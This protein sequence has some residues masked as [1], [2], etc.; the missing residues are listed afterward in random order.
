MEIAKEKYEIV[1]M[2][3]DTVVLNMMHMES[4]PIKFDIDIEET[5]PA[6][7][8]GDE[9]RIKQ[10]INNVLSNAFK[11][12][13]EGFVK[14]TVR[15][16]SKDSDMGLVDLIVIISDTGQGMTKDQIDKLFESYAR[17]NV[18]ANRFI[19]GSG[20]GMSI[21]KSIMDIMRGDII[22]E[23][24][25]DK[26]STFTIRIPQIKVGDQQ[27]GKGVVS[28]LNKFRYGRVH[29]KYARIAQEPMP[30]G[31]V[32][33]VDDVEMNIYVARGLLAPYALQIDAVDS[34]FAAI[35]RI[36]DGNEYDI[37]FMDHMMPQMDGIEA[38]KRIR[39]MGYSLPIVALTANA[40]AGQ[41][42]VFLKSGFDD[43]ISKPIDIRQLNSVLN[44]FIRDKRAHEVMDMDDANV[45]K[46]EAIGVENE[47]GNEFDEYMKSSGLYDLACRD[48]L[49]VQKDFVSELTLAI[50]GNDLKRAHFLAHTL[51][52]MAG[53]IG[54]NV[55]VKL[56]EE[57]ESYL[58][59]DILPTGL[60]ALFLE[61]E[62]V[63]FDIEER[64]PQRSDSQPDDRVLDKE[65]AK[66]VFDK[67]A[68]LLKISSFDALSLVDELSQIPKTNKLIEQIESIDF[69]IALNTLEE[70]RKTLE[71]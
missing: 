50:E 25:P 71:V 45:A 40:I 15:S 57:T 42:D 2:I 62:R 44:K 52:G 13:D 67:L 20:L 24:E 39:D 29:M 64:Y 14:M 27:V 33:I 17:F 23:S 48:F 31:Q 5:I 58:R 43:F 22:V 65:K 63:L 53:L 8:L 54:E 19:E 4:K 6:Y 68:P 26:G 60:D 3:H 37:I 9:L 32:L 18:K 56:S 55:L 61:V 69:D 46:S 1:S 21:T 10:V 7:M 51:K 35:Q 38:T 12:T 41:L 36:K 11:Y 59:K 28:N 49:S 34:G 16:E 30:Y 47:S 70:L 66:E